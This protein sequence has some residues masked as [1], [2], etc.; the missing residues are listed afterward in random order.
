MPLLSWEGSALCEHGGGHCA[1]VLQCV[2]PTL[3]SPFFPGE[4]LGIQH[5]QLLSQDRCPALLK[6]IHTDLAILGGQSVSEGAGRQR[7]SPHTQ[8]RALA[9]WTEL[10]IFRVAL[11]PGLPR[12]RNL[13]L[14]VYVCMY[15]NM[16]MHIIER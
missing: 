16:A 8:G 3:L 2:Y 13:A 10:F 6:A 12:K 11:N 5:Q 14:Y 15:N 9:P 7:E 4:I 1:L